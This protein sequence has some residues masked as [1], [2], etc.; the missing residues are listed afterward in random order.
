MA[1]M[2]NSNYDV[3]V[4]FSDV[5]FQLALAAN[6]Q[7]HVTIPGDF[8]NRYAVRFEYNDT[9]NVFARMDAAAVV[10]PG[11]TLTSVPYQEFRPGQ[12]GSQRYAT[13]GQTISFITPDATAY[14][15]VSLRS[16]P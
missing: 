5:C 7:Q 4:P 6:V 10:P 14:V 16:L 3:T 2:Y 15:G 11:G 1:I 8:N 13:G 12:D 9:S